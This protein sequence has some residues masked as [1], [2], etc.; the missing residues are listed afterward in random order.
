MKSLPGGR[1]EFD[2]DVL[3]EGLQGKVH[4]GKETTTGER[5]AIKF[6]NKSK[7]N[8]RNLDRLATEVKILQELSDDHVVGF[9]GYYPDFVLP[10]NSG[11]NGLGWGVI[12]M[13]Y[14]PFDLFDYLLAAGYFSEDLSRTYFCQLL[15]GLEEC[16][17]MGVYHRDIKPENLLL[18]RNFQLKLADFGLAAIVRGNDCEEDGETD[19]ESGGSNYAMM[20][21]RGNNLLRSYCGSNAYMSPE[22]FASEP[23]EGSHA[24]LWSSACVL[25]VM[26]SGFQPFAFPGPT[27]WWL[28]KILENR[29]AR[30]WQAHVKS[31]P[32]MSKFERGPSGGDGLQNLI[33]GMFRARPESRYTISQI[34]SHNWMKNGRILD[35]AELNWKMAEAEQH[36]QQSKEDERK[37]KA[38]KK[39]QRQKQFN[40]LEK[41]RDVP[42]ADAPVLPDTMGSILVEPTCFYTALSGSEMLLEIEKHLKSLDSSCG[43]VLDAKKFTVS[44]H[45]LMFPGLIIESCEEEPEEQLPSV[46][47]MFDVQLFSCMQPQ[48][49]SIDQISN[50]ADRCTVVRCMLPEPSKAEEVTVFRS[51]KKAK[52]P[53]SDIFAFLKFVD[54]LRELAVQ[55]EEEH[56]SKSGNMT[57]QPSVEPETELSDSLAMY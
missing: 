18:D 54:G 30:F 57:T 15:D 2:D 11:G 39:A 50:S 20:A 53:C 35:A 37:R 40:G 51:A 13:E 9:R 21:S 28:N 23:Y 7:L 43:F 22:V 16:H 3:G 8:Q 19:R 27:D 14:C 45:N 12:V 29:H 42:C 44:I 1:Y 46:P 32:H 31:G 48:A 41:H 4:L 47:L 10:F 17:R 52:V 56:P 55:K 24:D 36:V 25:F 34:R 5:V 6:I 26:V 38:E 49:D 33:N